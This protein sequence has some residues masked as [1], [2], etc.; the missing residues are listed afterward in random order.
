MT[1]GT[2]FR[3]LA[4]ALLGACSTRMDGIA[5]LAMRNVAFSA[6]QE[7]SGARA[8]NADARLWLFFVPIGRPPNMQHA[9]ADLLASRWADYLLNVRLSAGGFSLIAISF[10]WV[11][12]E[13]DPWRVVGP[14]TFEV[15]IDGVR[16]K[17][18]TAVL[19]PTAREGRSP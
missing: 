18:R 14:S 19:H 10:G 3:V 1:R 13:G 17:P 7:P 5:V 6:R 12:V 16:G 2:P 8:S 9:T 4:L 15:P 11:S